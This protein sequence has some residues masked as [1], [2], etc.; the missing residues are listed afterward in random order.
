MMR[1]NPDYVLRTVAGEALLVSEGVGRVDFN[2]MISL[3]G[4]AAWLWEKARDAGGEFD[5]AVLVEW[6]TGEYEVDEAAAAADVHRV[7][8]V[9]KEYGVIVD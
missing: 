2:N 3:N 4:P 7:L 5:E 6:L 8:A 9:W 1:L